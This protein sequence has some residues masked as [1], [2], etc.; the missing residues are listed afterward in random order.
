LLRQGS[1]G[2]RSAIDAGETDGDDRYEDDHVHDAVEA[3]QTGIERTKHEWRCAVCI[4]VA[5]IE[6]SFIGRRDQEADEE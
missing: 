4:G 3:L 2:T 5:G 6:Q 1:Q